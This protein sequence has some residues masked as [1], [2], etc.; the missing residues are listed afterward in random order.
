MNP[1]YHIPRLV[2]TN[3]ETNLCAID[4]ARY[5][6]VLVFMWLGSECSVIWYIQL[7]GGIKGSFF[8]LASAIFGA[9]PACTQIERCICQ[10]SGTIK[11]RLGTPRPG[12]WVPVVRLP[13]VNRGLGSDCLRESMVWLL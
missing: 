10:R 9:T 5:S 12:L 11:F 1:I 7:L 3:L 13:I 6:I 2:S 8:S 4:W